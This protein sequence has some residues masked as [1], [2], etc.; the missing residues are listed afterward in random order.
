MP[1]GVYDK[2]RL[3]R[4]TEKLK[5]ALTILKNK[6]PYFSADPLMT[7]EDIFLKLKEFGFVYR[8]GVWRMTLRPHANGQTTTKTTRTKEVEVQEQ[9][10]TITPIAQTNR[11]EMVVSEENMESLIPI[12]QSMHTLGFKV[13]IKIVG[14]K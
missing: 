2:S 10:V 14:T 4:K 11:L 9:V 8:E 1:R 6:D 3:W 5:G 13:E 12:V 7:N